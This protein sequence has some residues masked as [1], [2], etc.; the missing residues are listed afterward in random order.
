MKRNRVN[1]PRREAAIRAAIIG[2]A[3]LESEL[4][5]ETAERAVADALRVAKN[6]HRRQPT[7]GGWDGS[8]YVATVPELEALLVERDLEP[9]QAEEI[10]LAESILAQNAASEPRICVRFWR[11]WSVEGA[12]FY[13]FELISSNAW[14]QQCSGAAQSSAAVSTRTEQSVVVAQAPGPH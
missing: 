4:A 2:D 12:P 3:Q 8:R 6:L 1:W 7:G 5:R 14:E 9:L 13:D 11:D 10:V